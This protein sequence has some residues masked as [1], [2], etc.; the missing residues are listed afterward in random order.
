[1]PYVID[2]GVPDGSPDLKFHAAWHLRLEGRARESECKR[3]VFFRKGTE[4]ST[5]ISSSSASANMAKL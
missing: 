3:A 5:W 4:E 1:M 2:G